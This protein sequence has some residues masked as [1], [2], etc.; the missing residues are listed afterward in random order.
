MMATRTSRLGNILLGV[1]LAALAY[2]AYE[3]ALTK[4]I[5]SISPLLGMAGIA[6][7]VWYLRFGAPL[8][9]ARNFVQ[10][11]PGALGPVTQ[12]IGPA[13]VFTED[14]RGQAR[15]AWNA[16]Q[17]VRETHAV[18]LLYAQSNLATIVPKRCFNGPGDIQ[19]YRE[20]IRRHCAGTLDLQN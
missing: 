3:A 7:F 5:H 14:T 11:N 15:L 19:T 4:A 18:F 2:F 13:G 16:F 20:I 6:L 12:T 17:R 9:A 10:E 8:L 1:S